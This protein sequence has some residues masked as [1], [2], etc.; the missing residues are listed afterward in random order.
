[1]P[2]TLVPTLVPT[3]P[4]TLV[5]TEVGICVPGR[6][7]GATKDAAI[8]QVLWHWG[9]FAGDVHK[10]GVLRAGAADPFLV[11]GPGLP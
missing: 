8:S 2:A 7:W 1:M 4:A 5:P 10:P 11:L 3:M 9:E 6:G